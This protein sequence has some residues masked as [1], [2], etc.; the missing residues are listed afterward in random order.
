MDVNSNKKGSQS[1][2]WKPFYGERGA[3][4]AAV[5]LPAKQDDDKQNCV[6][7]QQREWDRPAHAWFCTGWYLSPSFPS[8]KNASTINP[9]KVASATSTSSPCGE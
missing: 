9:A 8:L 5:G 1:E 4:V 6:D 3:H 2:D 7:H